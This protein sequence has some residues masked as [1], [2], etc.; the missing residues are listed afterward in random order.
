M[1]NGEIVE[2]RINS[3]FLSRVYAWMS[4]GLI[5]T[6][7]VSYYISTQP[8][9]ISAFF[10]NFGLI[11]ILFLVQI[12][13]VAALSFFISKMSFATATLA[14]LAYSILTG[15]TIS[16]I[17]LVYTK[18]SIAI[19]FLIT[20]AMFGAMALYGYFTKK[21]LSGMSSFLFMSLIGLLIALIVN[22]FLKSESFDYIISAF[23]VIIF[24]LLTAFD[25]QQIKRLGSQLITQGENTSKASIIGALKLYLDFINL[26]L[27]LLRFTGR[28]ND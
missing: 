11:L 10:N 1:T 22:I 7:L 25:V 27:F 4:V 12:I 14:F 16:S 21:D 19:T 6:G 9:I 18:S 24:S 20:A 8:K 23:G 15:I 17:F 2:G 28:K 5:I 26:F 3:N 13:L